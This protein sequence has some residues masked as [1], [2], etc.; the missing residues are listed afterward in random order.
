[1][2][3][4][5]RFKPYAAYKDSGVD[6]LGEIPAHWAVKRLRTTVGSCQNGVGTRSDWKTLVDRSCSSESVMPRSTR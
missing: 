1:M 6:W 4:L 2:S 5:R 3:A